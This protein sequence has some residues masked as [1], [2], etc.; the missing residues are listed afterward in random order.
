MNIII[1]FLVSL[2]VNRKANGYSF[3]ILYPNTLP[4]TFLSY[5]N[6]WS[7]IY[8]NTSPSNKDTLTSYFPVCIP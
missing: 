7:Y 4:N 8:I 6:V 1:S 2:S 5:Q 3:L